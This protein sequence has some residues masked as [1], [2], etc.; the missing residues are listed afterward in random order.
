[1][2]LS[3]QVNTGGVDLAGEQGL[4]IGNETQQELILHG[5]RNPARKGHRRTARG[6]LNPTVPQRQRTTTQVS[7]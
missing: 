1:M 5:W 4:V 7:F 6:E 3:L 2:G